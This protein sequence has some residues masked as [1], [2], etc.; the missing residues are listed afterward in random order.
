MIGTYVEQL[1]LIAEELKLP[2][3]TGKTPNHIRERLFSQ[4]RSE[5]NQYPNRVKV[6]NY[7]D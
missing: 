6:A 3:I 4:F 1:H 5:M 2:V 7:T